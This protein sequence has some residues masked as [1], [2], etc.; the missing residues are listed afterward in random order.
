[1]RLNKC[2]A[3]T[4]KEILG[5]WKKLFVLAARERKNREGTRREEN[6]QTNNQSSPMKIREEPME[7]QNRVNEEKDK[8]PEIKKRK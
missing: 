4:A 3:Y 5:Y 2:D 8:H 6:P 1:M 7:E